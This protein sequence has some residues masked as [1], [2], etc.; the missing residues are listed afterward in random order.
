MPVSPARLALREKLS[1]EPSRRARSGGEIT[2][3]NDVNLRN[4]TAVTRGIPAAGNSALLL[5]VVSSHSTLRRAANLGMFPRSSVVPRRE[6]TWA[7][8]VTPRAG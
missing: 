7:A 2:R 4:R 8:A 1:T 6:G 5:V 3:R